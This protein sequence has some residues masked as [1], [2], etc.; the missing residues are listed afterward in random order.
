MK[1]KKLDSAS[2][3]KIEDLRN[4]IAA[5]ENVNCV[6]EVEGQGLES[7]I[8]EYVQLWGLNYIY[9]GKLVGVNESNVLLEDCHVVY[10]TGDFTAKKFKWAEKLP[11]DLWR[12]QRGH[13]ESY[14]KAPQ[15]VTLK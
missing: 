14:G 2:Q 5:L 15:M 12:V 7:L 8:G 9:A 1:A 6:V 4:Q 11:D 10:E 3:K 13:F